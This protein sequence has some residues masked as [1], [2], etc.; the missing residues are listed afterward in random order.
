MLNLRVNNRQTPTQPQTP[1]AVSQE[2]AAKLAQRYND[3]EISIEQL[4]K[5]RDLANNKVRLIMLLPML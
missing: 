2:I 1:D 3:G 5:I 4:A